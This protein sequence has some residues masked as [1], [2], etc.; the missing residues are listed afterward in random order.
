MDQ[1]AAAARAL[2]T[3]TDGLLA[4]ALETAI[5]VAYM[6]PF[7]GGPPGRLA[8]DYQSREHSASEV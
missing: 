8:D 6:R 1:A 2:E 7:T 3:E 5:A 4:R